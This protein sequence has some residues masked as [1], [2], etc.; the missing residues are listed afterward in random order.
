METTTPKQNSWDRFPGETAIVANRQ[1]AVVGVP[2]VVPPI[3]VEL[4]LGVVLVEI[5]HVAVAIN[6]TNGALCEK[7]SMALLPESFTRAVSNP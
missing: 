3:E 1:E 7:P 6:L 2:V 4:A 5:R